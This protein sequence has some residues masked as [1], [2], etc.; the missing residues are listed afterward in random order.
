MQLV[1]KFSKVGL[2]M[3]PCLT[4]VIDRNSAALS[5]Y[6]FSAVNTQLD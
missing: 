5:H 2:H 1:K 6:P 4:A 3:T